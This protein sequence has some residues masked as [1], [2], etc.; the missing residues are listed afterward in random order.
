MGLAG[1]ASDG[2]LFGRV[3]NLVVAAHRRLRVRLI[4]FG[5]ASRFWVITPILLLFAFL[6]STASA[7]PQR[8]TIAETALNT[9]ALQPGQQ[10]VVAVRVEIHA[11]FHTQSHSP[12]HGYIP[13][14]ARLSANPAIAVLDP[15]YPAGQA[16]FYPSLGALNVYSGTITVYL[17]I[18]VNTSA[19]SGPFTLTGSIHEQTCDENQCYAP[20]SIPFSIATQ[21]VP[22]GQPMHPANGELFAGF[23]PSYF[24]KVLKAT[25]PAA[26]AAAAGAAGASFDIFGWHFALQKDS[27]GLALSIAFVVGIIFNLMPCVLPCVPLKIIGFYEVSQHHRG[28]SVLLSAIFSLGIL[29]VFAVLALLVLVLHKIQ[30]G[31]EYSNPW[32]VWPLVAVLVIMAGGMF[33][34]FA[35]PLPTAVYGLAPRHDTVSG[36]FFFGVL[37]AVLST[38]CTAPMFAGV[39]AWSALQPTWLSVATVMDVGAG[40][41]FPYLLLSGF[42]EVARKFPRTGP[43]AELLKQTMAFALLAVAVWLAGGQLAGSV[44]FVWAVYAVVAAGCLFLVVRTAQLAPRGRPILISTIIAVVIAGGAIWYP[45]R[46][47]AGNTGG[48]AESIDWRPY[49]DASLREG[50][51]AGRIVM[52]EFTANWCPNC[53]ELEARVFH[54]PR[55][56]D[57]I[58]SHD[59]LT[60]RADLT[61]ESAPGW[62]QLRRLNASGGIPL[63]ALYAPGRSEPMELTSTYTTQNLIDALGQV[64]KTETANTN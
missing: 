9:D 43:W 2:G 53:L 46:L 29:A 55:A 45:L 15:V 8:V 31:Q 35:V 38:P 28:R 34:W 4:P 27:W 40:M 58:R 50:Q 21:V 64:K 44:K 12:G 32:F 25:A 57:A 5:A 18:E 14:V 37:T 63:T 54:D 42:P 51:A 48:A 60:L 3:A 6:A 62:A 36:N 59:V 26:P 23:D 52:V 47:T 33:G 49:S 41:A 10:A 1:R 16:R 61:D 24:A 7:A 19:A 39:L 22:T 56:A 20:E 30:W 11:G 13:F 17:P